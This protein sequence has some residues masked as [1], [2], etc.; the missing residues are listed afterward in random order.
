MIGELAGLATSFCW[1]FTSI[2]FTLSGR[3]VGSPIVNRTRLVLALIMVSLMHWVTQGQILPVDASPARWGWFALSGLIGFVIGDALL[4]QA[5]VMIGPRLSMLL[6]A[7]NPVMGAIMAWVLLD[8]TLAAVEIVGIL[9][10]IGGVMWVIVDRQHNGDQQHNGDSQLSGDASGEV[11]EESARAGRRAYLIGVLFGLGGAL[12][13]AGG[14]IASKQGLSDDFPALSGNLM[15]LVV[16]TLV[17]WGFTILQGSARPTVRTLRAN[18][19]A[20][21]FILI[22]AV[23][24]PFIGVTLSLIAVQNAPVGIAST[25][26]SLTPVVLLVVDRVWFHE[27]ITR[28][29][30]MGTVLAVIGTAILFL[31]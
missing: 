26:M 16:S 23:V 4:F 8:E 1:S 9:L 27:R 3:L 18:P 29:A 31:A 19:M 28:R 30:V 5:F 17:I 10:A 7:L 6:M 21:R 11:S 22:G 25:L 2:F 12:G 15:R 14:L 20:I 24:G 13:Q